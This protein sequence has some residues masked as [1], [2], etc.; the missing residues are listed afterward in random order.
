M[1]V[2]AAV[3]KLRGCARIACPEHVLMFGVIECAV[4]EAAEVDYVAPPPPE[5]YPPESK[6][7]GYKQQ[8]KEDKASGARKF[9]TT[10]NHE[11]Y[12][13]SVDLDP[14][15]VMRVLRYFFPWAA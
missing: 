10:G 8:P 9:F 5:L 13:R 14:E 3:R 6:K 2:S 7:R 15:Y 12:A 4:R 1:V 11:W